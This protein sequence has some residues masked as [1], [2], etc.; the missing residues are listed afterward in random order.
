MGCGASL[1]R[2]CTPEEKGTLCAAMGKDMMLLCI[3]PA[4]ENCGQIIVPAPPEVA[5]LREDVANLRKNASDMKQQMADTKNAEAPKT[6]DGGS[7]GM[8]GSMMAKGAAMVEKAT[9]AV[10]GG[11]VATVEFT[12][13]GLADQLEKV[14]NTVEE[15]FTK[16]GK[17]IVAEK[18]DKIKS[19]FEYYIANMPLKDSGVAVSLIRGDESEGSYGNIQD[20]LTDHLCRKSAKNLVAQLLP[21]CEEAIKQHTVTKCW[22]SVIENY[23]SVS[24]KIASFDF[25][26]K[27]GLTLK[28]IELD[29]KDYI[30]SQCLEQIALLMAK[31]EAQRRKEPAKS[32]RTRTPVTF[33]TVFSEEVLNET[34]YNRYT[35]KKDVL[36]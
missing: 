33:D 17:E 7:Q 16:V 34:L 31:E 24:K 14:V 2:E 23:N 5:R 29:I 35:N 15:P 9:D 6:G 18:K 8:L 22:D 36:V 21:V 3:G 11:A 12:L 10:V 32:G 20:A 4:L 26:E 1:A 19:V 25:A 27:N 13:N 28:P 30:V